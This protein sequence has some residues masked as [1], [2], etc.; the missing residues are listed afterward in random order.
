MSSPAGPS[1]R[2]GVRER[3]RVATRQ[4]IEAAAIQLFSARGFEAPTAGEIAALAGVSVR[5]FFR[6]FPGGKEDVMLQESR[7]AM[8]DLRRALEARPPHESALVALRAA[9]HSLPWY[10][11]DY[12]DDRAI[13]LFSQIASSHR[14][15]LAR[16]LG[17]RQLLAE[18]LV[19]LVALRMSTDPRTDLRPRLLLHGLHAAMTTTWLTWIADPGLDLPALFD[20]ALDLLEQGMADVMA[21]GRGATVR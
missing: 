16:M 7:R 15:L 4:A 8:D 20:S 12:G 6:Y 10:R 18:T 11:Q 17:E 13:L 5:T 2:P 9:T 1:K 21:D 3:Q 14:D 19:E